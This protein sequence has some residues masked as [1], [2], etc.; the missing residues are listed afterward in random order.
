MTTL[1]TS[2]VEIR[3]FQPGSVEETASLHEAANLEAAK[4]LV[5]A[6]LPAAQFVRCCQQESDGGCAFVYPSAQEASLDEADAAQG[7][8]D[9]ELPSSYGRWVGIISSAAREEPTCRR[10]AAPGA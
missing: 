3:F 6:Q 1:E 8:A 2:R 5:R 10:P 7:E 9:G 4:E